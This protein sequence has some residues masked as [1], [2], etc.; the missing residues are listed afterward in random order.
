MF[1]LTD[2]LFPNP[3]PALQWIKFG[4]VVLVLCIIGACAVLY[5]TRGRRK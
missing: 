4:F 5:V 3:D 2:G 1:P